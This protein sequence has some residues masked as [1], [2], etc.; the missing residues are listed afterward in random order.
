MNTKYHRYHIFF[1]VVLALV[2]HCG[3]FRITLA[4]TTSDSTQARPPQYSNYVLVGGGYA[5]G[6]ATLNRLGFMYSMAYGHVFSSHIDAECSVNITKYA[7]K[8]L[9]SGMGI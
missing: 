9:P 1:V 3:S 4:S 5:L 8:P 2:L 7:V 6:D